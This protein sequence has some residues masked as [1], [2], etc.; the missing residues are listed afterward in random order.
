MPRL[1]AIFCCR[2]KTPWP[3]AVYGGKSLF[4]LGSR[5]AV[6]Y[7]LEGWQQVAGA[8]S[9]LITFPQSKQTRNW[10]RLYTLKACPSDRLLQ[11][12]LHLL[13]VLTP[14][15]DTISWGLSVQILDCRRDSSHS[16]HY[17]K[18][19]HQIVKQCNINKT[20]LKCDSEN[21]SL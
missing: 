1:L 20:T 10:E 18:Y 16:N 9:W 2:V 7:N 6:H 3:K 13:K 5:G 14:S 17:T 8:R 12:R 15:N 11:A 4:G 19:S 21:A